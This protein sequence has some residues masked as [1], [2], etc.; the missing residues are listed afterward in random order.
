MSSLDTF[1]KKAAA[2]GIYSYD[3]GTDTIF[4]RAIQLTTMNPGIEKRIV[5]TVSWTDRGNISRSVSAEEHLFNW[6]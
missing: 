5:V 1:L 4:K 6:R 2:T 3:A